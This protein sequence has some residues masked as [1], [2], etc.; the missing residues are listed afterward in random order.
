[1]KPLFGVIDTVQNRDGVSIREKVVLLF[2][3][4]I[5]KLVECYPI[6]KY[7]PIGFTCGENN[8]TYVEDD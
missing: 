2:G 6:E 5:Y 7:K 3:V 8:L 4:T 1:M